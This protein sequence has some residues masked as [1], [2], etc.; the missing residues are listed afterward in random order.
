MK[1]QLISKLSSKRYLHSLNVMKAAEEL[2][3]NF[4][5]DAVKASVAGLLHD[6]AKYLE[7][8]KIFELCRLYNIEINEYTLNQ[9]ELLH[10][11]IGASMAKEIYG[12][13]DTDI[14]HAIY[15]H[16]TGCEDM[17][18]LDKI[19]FLADYIEPGRNFDGVDDI[20][21]KAYTNIE[22]AIALSFAS[23]IKDVLKKGKLLYP[24]TI[25]ARNYI[26]LERLRE[27]KKNE[28]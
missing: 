21:Q 13:S 2:A 6:C 5:E 8:D 3:L 18:M 7:H 17:T 16:T 11:P 28:T 25:D 20:R 9:P 1:L 27:R 23:T 4:G 22:E 19:I 26:I 14:L 10:G 12:I 15:F 24:I